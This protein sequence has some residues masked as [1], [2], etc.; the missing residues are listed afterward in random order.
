MKRDRRDASEKDYM[1]LAGLISK[2]TGLPIALDHHYK[3]LVLLAQESDPDLEA[4]R[5]YFGKLKN[6]ELYFRGIE[7]RRRDY[8][9]FI[10]D[11]QV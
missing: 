4:T 3:F 9:I 1:D 11:F 5:R 10:K 2:R 6:G 8:P 7:L